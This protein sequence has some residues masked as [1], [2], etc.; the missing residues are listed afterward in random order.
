VSAGRVVLIV[1]GTLAVLL[2][3]ALLAAGGFV[4]WA[5]QTQR[6][7]GYLTTPS[8]RF[9][10]TTSALTRERLEVD[11]TGPDWVWSDRFFGHIR[12][13]GH[14]DN[15]KR[16][17]VGIGPAAAV[18]AYLARVGHSEVED[19]EFDPFRVTYN[20]V[21][22]GPPPRPPTAERFWAVSSAGPGSRTVTWKVRD[23]DWSV[24]VMNAD[25]SRGVVALLDVGARFGFLLWLA[26]G[27]LVGGAVVLGVGALLIVLGVRERPPRTARPAR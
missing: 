15:G 22:G 2:G 16:L 8:E 11:S 3:L 1:I 10:T 13:R 26:V 17:F 12:I 6:E 21:A 7:D 20:R 14:A 18:G 9:A 25:G 5:D 23:G 27:L 19:L 24:V 4:L